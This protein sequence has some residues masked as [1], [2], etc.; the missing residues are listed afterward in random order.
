MA[1][2]P[3]YERPPGRVNRSV[4]FRP[5]ERYCLPIAIAPPTLKPQPK[6]F[7]Y[8]VVVTEQLKA[9]ELK[10]RQKFQRNRL[11][12]SRRWWSRAQFYVAS[13]PSVPSR[14]SRTRNMCS[15]N[16]Q[17]S[18]VDSRANGSADVW[19]TVARGGETWRKAQFPPMCASLWHLHNYHCLSLQ[20]EC[21]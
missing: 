11:G 15:P 12:G 6:F 7:A 14:L 8:D 10:D 2:H 19:N 18:V 3:R 1:R 17:R 20:D 13:I 16:P 21:E 5:V 4:I 9:I